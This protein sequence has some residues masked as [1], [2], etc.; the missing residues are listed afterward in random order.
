MCI[1][2]REVTSHIATGLLYRSFRQLES[3]SVKIFRLL[4]CV[5]ELVPMKWCVRGHNHSSSCHYNAIRS[6]DLIVV[7]LA[8]L[9]SLIDLTTFR[10]YSFSKP[11]QVPSSKNP[12]MKQPPKG[13]KN[14]G[15]WCRN[16]NKHSAPIGLTTK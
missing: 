10:S 8:H 5:Y 14:I 3:N 13:F 15:N 2:K 11:V 12:S 1:G 16:I 6:C 7:K 9:C 4:K